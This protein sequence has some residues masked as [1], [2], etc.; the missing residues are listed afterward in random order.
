MKECIRAIDHDFYHLPFRQSKLTLVL[1]DSFVGD[2][3]TCMIA[4]ISPCMNSCEHTLNT[5][6]Y[7]YRVKELKGQSCLNNSPI[8]KFIVDSPSLY[9]SPKLTQPIVNSPLGKNNELN[10][11]KSVHGCF[12]SSKSN[13]EIV[14]VL[15]VNSIIASKIDSVQNSLALL[16]DSV[17]SCNDPDTL[18]LLNEE[19]NILYTAFV[20]IVQK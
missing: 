19:L 20:K 4:N 8:R 17:T 13:L 6:R 10:R 16:Y 2:A 7:A 1:K 11:R 14:K 5:L 9:S 12:E 18:D 15:D 3:K